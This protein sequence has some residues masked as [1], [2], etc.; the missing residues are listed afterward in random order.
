MAAY[1]SI[2]SRHQEGSYSDAF[3]RITGTA[4]FFRCSDC[5]DSLVQ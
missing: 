4:S 3:N 1:V 2:P 5:I